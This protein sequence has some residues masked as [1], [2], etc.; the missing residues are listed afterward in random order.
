MSSAGDL[1]VRTMTH[2]GCPMLWSGGSLSCD[3]AVSLKGL[4]LAQLSTLAICSNSY[5]GWSSR[6]C[7]NYLETEA[8]VGVVTR[9]DFRGF[10]E[11]KRP[12]RLL[13]GGNMLG[14]IFGVTFSTRPSSC[15]VVE[16]LTSVGSVSALRLLPW[17]ERMMRSLSEL[18]VR[19]LSLLT[20]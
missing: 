14:V 19:G 15:E 5:F 12:L 7:V 3:S 17:G 9:V 18:R 8:C 16:T 11:S 6:T 13:S 4:F 10:L 2:C 1:S 20:F